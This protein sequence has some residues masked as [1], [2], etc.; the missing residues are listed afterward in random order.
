MVESQTA[1]LTAINAKIVSMT[2]GPTAGPSSETLVGG[3]IPFNPQ[4]M[5]ESHEVLAERARVALVRLQLILKPASK[6]ETKK[7]T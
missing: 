7:N 1:G 5:T 3:T 2:V 6:K 4:V